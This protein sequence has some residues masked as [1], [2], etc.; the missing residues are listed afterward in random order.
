MRQP[1]VQARIVKCESN[2]PSQREAART[3]Q[4]RL[5]RHW[6]S[7]QSAPCILI[8][9]LQPRSMLLH[10]SRYVTR[11]ISERE[12]K[13]QSPHHLS[14]DGFGALSDML[15]LPASPPGVATGS[16]QAGLLLT[17]TTRQ[18]ASLAG[19][20]IYGSTKIK[21]SFIQEDTVCVR[22]PKRKCRNNRCPNLKVIA[23]GPRA[24]CLNV[25]PFRLP[26]LQA[27]SIISWYESR[28]A[29]EE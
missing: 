8:S 24:T 9:F 3:P 7:R 10:S 26:L 17:G 15:S 4:R 29:P 28:F 14:S 21:A 27:P 13:S 20:H 22:S 18:L 5:V 19:G 6:S 25:Q 2:N 23:L 12:R 16:P 11:P 1:K